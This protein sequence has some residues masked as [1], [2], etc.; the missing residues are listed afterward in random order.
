MRVICMVRA[1]LVMVVSVE[2]EER[3]KASSVRRRGPLWV[4]PAQR[5][6]P[7]PLLKAP[8][9]SSKRVVVFAGRQVGGVGADVM[10]EEAE[11]EQD[12][13]RAHRTSILCFGL[14][15]LVQ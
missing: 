9:A 10:G 13:D 14:C 4:V 8:W 11:T 5:Y 15:D 3:S 1:T 6:A 12:D 2:M 7:A